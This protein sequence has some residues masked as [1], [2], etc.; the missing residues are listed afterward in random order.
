MGIDFSP[1]SG[2]ALDVARA[3]FPSAQLRL[4]HVID[5]RVAATPDLGGGLVPATLDPTLLHTLE[6]A[7]ANRLA[8]LAREGEETELLV[9]DPV[10]GILNAAERWGAELIVVGTHSK[11]AIEHFFVGS[12]AEKLVARSP[13][14]VLTVRLPGERR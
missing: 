5:A 11:G 9:G 12:S 2:H 6:D 7:D 1:A 8:E 10:T 14:P 3:R 4:V 13:V